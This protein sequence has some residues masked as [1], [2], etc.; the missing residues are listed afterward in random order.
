[1]KKYSRN[2]IVIWVIVVLVMVGSIAYFMMTPAKK[3]YECSTEYVQTAGDA[4]C[5][6]KVKANQQESDAIQESQMR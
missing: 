5:L 3:D 4:D 1:M 2:E 6:N